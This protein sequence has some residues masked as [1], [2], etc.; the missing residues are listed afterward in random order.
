MGRRGINR[1]I[2]RQKETDYY[3][4]LLNS[5]TARY[6]YRILAFKLVFENPE[7]YNFK[8]SNNSLYHPIPYKEVEINTPVVSWADFA[9]DHGTNYK[10]IKILNPWLRESKLSNNSHKTY[11]IKVPRNGA[12][13][14]KE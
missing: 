9:K 1:Q 12:R 2:D 13:I 3:N 11:I 4:L 5:E 8:L 10:M 7:K 6:I 14:K